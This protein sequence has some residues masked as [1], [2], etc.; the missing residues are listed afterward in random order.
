MENKTAIEWLEIARKNRIRWV[1]QAIA[2]IA[3]QPNHEDRQDNYSSISA[4]ICLEFDWESSKEGFEYW[5][6]MHNLLLIAGN[7]NR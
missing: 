4:M 5:D 1:D 6:H 2:N 3:A 7:S